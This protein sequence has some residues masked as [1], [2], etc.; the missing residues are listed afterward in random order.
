M[1][2]VEAVE[3]F[4]PSGERE[5]SMSRFAPMLRW[6]YNLMTRQQSAHIRIIHSYKY[7]SKPPSDWL[8]NVSCRL[9]SQSKQREGKKCTWLSYVV[10]Y[11]DF[12]L[13]D[14]HYCLSFAIVVCYSV[15]AV[16]ITLV[17]H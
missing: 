17:C 5:K 4:F 6:L 13:F 9:S 1:V 3:K 7:F 16:S 8:G 15:Y 14:T 12:D 11:I 10:E 2:R